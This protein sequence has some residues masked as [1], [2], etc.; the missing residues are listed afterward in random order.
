MIFMQLREVNVL[1]H[2]LDELLGVQDP[3]EFGRQ[4]QGVK[5]L[6]GRWMQRMR[7]VTRTP[8]SAFIILHPLLSDSQPTN[9]A[10]RELKKLIDFARKELGD[11]LVIVFG[12]P[13]LTA[14]QQMFKAFHELSKKFEVSNETRF[15]VFGEH[16][17]YCVPLVCGALRT[18]EKEE[19][20]I[21]K[22]LSFPESS[23]RR[24]KGYTGYK[25]PSHTNRKKRDSPKIRPGKRNTPRRV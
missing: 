1:V 11:K 18:L 13:G 4:L 22:Q 23:K 24:G 19:I 15:K 5:I 17:E 21:E 2:P 25:R 14:E 12:F 8:N 10:E 9:N 3:Q 20:E 7:E 16:K 6:T